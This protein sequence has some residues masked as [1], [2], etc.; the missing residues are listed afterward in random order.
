MLS[1]QLYVWAMHAE[2]HRGGKS[3]NYFWVQEIVLY[4]VFGLC[5]KVRA[6]YKGVWVMYFSPSIVLYRTTIQFHSVK[7]KSLPCGSRQSFAQPFKSCVFCFLIFQL[8]LVCCA[9]GYEWFYF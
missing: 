6:D 1:L 9:C 7:K 8:S 4:L 2:V 3:K 5:E